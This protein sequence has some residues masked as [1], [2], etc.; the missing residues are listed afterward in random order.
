MRA[1]AQWCLAGPNKVPFLYLNGK[2]QNASPVS[3]P[4][5]TF[6][7]VIELAKQHSCYVGFILTSADPF[8]CID[9]DIKDSQSKKEDG[10]G[11][12]ESL[13]T[14]ED[15][16]ARYSAIVTTLDSY[17]ELSISGK[18]CHI[19]AKGTNGKGLKREGVEVYS[20]ERFIVCTGNSISS[21]KYRIDNHIVFP[22][23]E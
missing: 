23:I 12:P 4:W 18:G 5:H 15:R 16:L 2:W 7:E 9:L 13:W 14:N 8:V 1:L 20:Q 6:D 21:V 22:E 3:G 10:T 11:Y 19:W 17:T